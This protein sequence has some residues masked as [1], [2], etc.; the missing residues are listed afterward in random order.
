MDELC[1]KYTYCKVQLSKYVYLSFLETFKQALYA[2][3][4]EKIVAYRSIMIASPKED[5]IAIYLKIT[6]RV[7]SLHIK[8]LK[9]FK[10]TNEELAKN[11]EAKSQL[12]PVY[13]GEI[14]M[15]T[16]A[17]LTDYPENLIKVTL[18]DLLQSWAF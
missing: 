13:A 10:D 18:G 4:Q 11:P 3:G 5:L 12:D 17:F 15:L 1:K 16:G 9:I 2:Y 8:F 6:N 7:T 14:G